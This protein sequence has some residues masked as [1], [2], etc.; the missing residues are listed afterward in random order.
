MG[1]NDFDQ[2]F[3]TSVYMAAENAPHLHDCV[4]VLQCLLCQ[5][6]LTLDLQ[7]K[8]LRYIRHQHINQA[9]D[10]KHHML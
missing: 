10:P 9:A 5:V 1:Q 4:R 8:A 2:T 6:P 3:S 7:F